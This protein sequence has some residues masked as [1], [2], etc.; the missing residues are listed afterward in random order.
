MRTLSLCTTD[1]SG[2]ENPGRTGSLDVRPSGVPG[3]GIG[4]DGARGSLYVH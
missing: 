2:R 3:C 4:M 1:E